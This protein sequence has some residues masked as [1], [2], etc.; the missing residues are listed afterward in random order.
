MYIPTTNFE[1]I[2][3]YTLKFTLRKLGTVFSFAVK[4]FIYSKVLASLAKLKL[5]KKEENRPWLVAFKTSSQYV[6]L[7]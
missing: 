2:Y 6:V 7:Y 1:G 3:M 4:S 5:L